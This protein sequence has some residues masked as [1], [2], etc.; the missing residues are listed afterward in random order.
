MTMKFRLL[1][2]LLLAVP[3][4]A[5][6][7]GLGDIH[8]GS[9]L[10]Q[11]LSADI[12]LLGA[13]P[14]ELTQLRAGVAS[15]DIFARYGIDRPA[16]LSGL[17]FKVT[18]DA[19]GRNVLAVHTSDAVNEPFVTFLVELS[20]PRG[21][22]IREYTVLLDPPVFESQPSTA[23]PMAAPVTGTTSAP[24]SGTIERPV[25]AAP[26]PEAPAASGPPATAEARPGAAGGGDYNVVANDTLSMIVRRQGV[27]AP[28]DV[29]RLMIATFRANPAAFDFNIN[30]LRRGVVLHIPPESEWRAM[31]AHEAAG[32][33]SRQVQAWRVASGHAA[34]GHAASA[35]GGPARLR[36]VV[37][38]ETAGKGTEPAAPKAG[39]AAA[40]NPALA[41]QR[42]DA[43]RLLEFRNA[44][45]A[46]MQAQ[47]KA[48]PVAP[49]APAPAPTAKPAAAAPGA[50]AAPTPAPAE[51]A[52]ARPAPVVAAEPGFLEGLFGDNGL[53]YAAIA[54]LAALVAGLVG[55]KLWRRRRDSASELDDVLQPVAVAEPEPEVTTQSMASSVSR[56][57][58]GSG[59]IVVEES[60]DASGEYSPPPFKSAETQSM[61]RPGV[62][63]PVDSRLTAESSIGL[64][65]ADP[66]AEAD[67]HMAYGLYDQAADIVR[68]AIEREPGRRD[69][70]LKL[71]EVYFVWGNKDAFIDVART[72]ARGRDEAPAAEW[73]KVAIMGRQIAPDDPL[74]AASGNATSGADIDL[75]LDAGA[76]RGVDLELLG[77]PPAGSGHVP[78]DS[79]DLDLGRAL[80]GAD[81]STDTGESPTI[82]PDRFDLLLEP[83]HPDHS[84]VTTQEMPVRADAPTVEQPMLG[85]GTRD[86]SPTVEM[87]AYDTG[88]TLTQK[89]DTMARHM[90]SAGE[91]TAEISIDD[92]G[93][94]TDSLSSTSLSALNETDQPTLGPAESATLVAG[95]DP[96]SRSRLAAIDPDATRA[97]AHDME[98]TQETPR[99]KPADDAT[100]LAPRLGDSAPTEQMRAF[101]T[102]E[103][104][105][106]ELSSSDLDLDLDELARALENDT[107]AQPRRDE[108]RFSTDVFATGLHKA[109]ANGMDLDVGAALTEHREPTATERMPHDLD[110]PE[111]EPVTLSE[112]GTKLDLARAYMDMG[113]PDGARSILQEVLT[114]GSASQKVEAQRLIE[115]LPR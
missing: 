49:P 6:A 57:A 8:L 48:K 5:H 44:E 85:R 61:L 78:G 73:D 30:R 9:A 12:E 109:P 79:V 1:F 21:H 27:S 2:G 35:A 90:P 95:L 91:S 68:A 69:L 4:A 102:P 76:T 81:P 33:V 106:I 92:L 75:D 39:P 80:A 20:W 93:L 65:Q 111:L 99:P 113:D 115:T 63:P 96:A 38:K 47:P 11:P 70:Q 105:E 45:L 54:V 83:E 104:A 41:K 84:G 66:L 36:L 32:E 59:A 52:A 19:A 55:F 72:L 110:L 25:E 29:N 58:E 87:P 16:F 37:P 56:R 18:K 42:E 114:E 15:R 22:L 46:R 43:R 53:F 108:V 3:A 31:D 98:P 82:D 86:E 71:L 74:F 10:N 94:E 23:P 64:D 77:E 26:A 67:F 101:D 60:Q 97:A 34:G 100:Q 40:A 28:A 62:E 24:A 7:V 50:T 103:A 107:V 14:E 13:T 88:S 17:T 89:L 112:V 51:P